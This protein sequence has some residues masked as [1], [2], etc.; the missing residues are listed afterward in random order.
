M[1]RA[2]MESHVEIWGR[3]NSTNVRKVLWCAEE[4]GLD[5]TSIPAGGAFGAMDKALNPNGLV[6][7]IRDGDFVLWESNA[8]VRYLVSRYGRAPF[9]RDDVQRW[10]S[11]ERWMDWTS[12]GFSGPYRDLYWNLVRRGPE[13]RDVAAMERGR[14]ECARLLAIADAA[15]AEAPY[16]SGD[17][18]GIG[19]IPLGP[20][21]YA[22]FSLPIARPD[23]PHLAAW[24]ERL[25]ERPAFRKGVMTTLD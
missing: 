2:M 15:L 24:Y 23:L 17:E 18:I 20:I 14:A 6:P 22:W 9:L 3:V 11:A 5:Y 7:C 13:E 12:I 21:A 1:Q 25:T 16:L 8:I 19:D 10:A 4:L